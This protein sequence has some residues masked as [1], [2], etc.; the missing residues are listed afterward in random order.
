[1]ECKGCGKCCEGD[2]YILLNKEEVNK[3]KKFQNSIGFNIPIVN[4][5]IVNIKDDCPYYLN[6]SKLCEIH[7]DKP[8]FC[9]KLYCL[10]K[11]LDKLNPFA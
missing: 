9:K 3:Y 1:M 11:I 7:P 4:W 6:K 5:S 10:E 2:G 8:N